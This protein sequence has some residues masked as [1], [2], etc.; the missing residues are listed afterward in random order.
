[1]GTSVASV[2]AFELDEFIVPEMV[3]PAFIR[4]PQSR[5]DVSAKPPDDEPEGDSEPKE[6]K[7]PYHSPNLGASILLQAIEDYRGSDER[8][9]RSAAIFLFPKTRAYSEHLSWAIGQTTMNEHHTRL[10]FE[11]LRARWDAEREKTRNKPCSK[12]ISLG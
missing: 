10:Q 3:M 6:R 5:W 12:P 1:M 9:H 7:I 11:A 2:P 4:R 8:V